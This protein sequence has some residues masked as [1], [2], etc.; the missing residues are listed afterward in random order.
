MMFAIYWKDPETQERF[1]LASGQRWRDFYPLTVD[2][3][4]YAQSD[5]A[6]KVIRAWKR[7]DK[8]SPQRTKLTIHDAKGK[9]VRYIKSFSY[10]D[11]EVVPIALVPDFTDTID[12]DNA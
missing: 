8:N 3:V 1:C 2:P 9:E 11:I 6:R 12:G 5:N 7:E 4:L 10:K